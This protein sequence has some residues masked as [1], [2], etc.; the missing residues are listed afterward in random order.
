MQ[1]LI[2]VVAKDMLVLL[3]VKIRNAIISGGNQSNQVKYSAFRISKKFHFVYPS[4]FTP[5]YSLL[6]VDVNG[7]T[8]FK[9][10]R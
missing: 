7:N 4:D 5:D 9:N 8:N 6:R 10:I 1:L 3:L 2:L